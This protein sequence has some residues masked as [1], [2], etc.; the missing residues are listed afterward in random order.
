MILE[1]LL[2]E[3]EK[4]SISVFTKDDLINF[5]KVKFSAHDYSPIESNGIL[6]IPE[7]KEIIARGKKLHL[8]KK[9]FLLTH[10]LI[11]NRNKVLTRDTILRKVWTED[12]IVEPRT[13]D[14]HIRKI[15]KN[16]EIDCIKTRKGIGYSWIEK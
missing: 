3:I 15:R 2:S 8:P 14:V 6:V 10:Y 4:S 12:V 13:I 1:N 16:L 9:Q 7:N 5:L 11:L